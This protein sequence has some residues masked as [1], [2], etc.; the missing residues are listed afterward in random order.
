MT[1]DQDVIQRLKYPDLARAA[2]M[3]CNLITRRSQAVGSDD[4]LW[5]MIYDLAE[6]ARDGAEIKAPKEDK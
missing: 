3:I 1:D 4:G 5:L 6:A 2:H